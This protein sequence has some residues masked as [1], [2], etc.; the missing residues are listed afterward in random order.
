MYL[1]RWAHVGWRRPRA[2]V[3]Q[4]LGA[5]DEV[6]ASSGYRWGYRTLPN[7]ADRPSSLRAF[8][9]EQIPSRAFHEQ[10]WLHFTVY[11]PLLTPHGSIAASMEHEVG[12]H[13]Q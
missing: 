1:D 10:H 9:A 11:I 2:S 12:V 3:P 4:Y 13:A 5:Q 8:Y 7:V 6:G